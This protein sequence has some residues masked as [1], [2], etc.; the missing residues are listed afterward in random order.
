MKTK[1]MLNR[2][3][4]MRSVICLLLC[5]PAALAAC[6]DA[7]VLVHGNTAA[8][9]SWNNTYNLLLTKGYTAAQIQRPAWGS[10]SCAACN[11]HN[12]SEETPVRTAIQNALAS[13]CT[14][15]IDVIGHSMG[16]TLA[17]QQITK[18]GIQSQVDAFVGVA[19]A[20]RGL[21]SCGVYPFNV[22]TST[23]GS[24]GLSVG[25]PFLD[26]LYGVRFGSRVYSI[27]SNIDQVVCS[28][29]SCLVYGVHS[30]SIWGQ[31]ATY[32]YALGHFGLQTDTAATQYE[33]I[34]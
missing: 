29:G 11:D 14:G 2:V 1:T 32:T 26:G 22:L 13:S 27:K 17:A 21:L 33:L 3:L 8:P 7:V 4:L 10:S 20:F 24:A 19:G 34:K 25:N 31:N 28:S 12:G 23:C 30:S 9:S 15:K 16:A 5:S 18:L 6:L